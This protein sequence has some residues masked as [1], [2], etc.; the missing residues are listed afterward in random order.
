MEDKSIKEWAVAQHERVNQ[1]YGDGYPYKLHLNWVAAVARQFICPQTIFRNDAEVRVVINAC[2]LHDV[3][4][5][6][7]VS[8]NDVK[9]EC[10][11]MLANIAFAL[12]NEK[13][14]TRAERANDKYY[15]GIRA[16]KFADYVKL[17]D[18]IANMEYNL[19]FGGSML[20]KYR[21][22]REEFIIKLEV[23][24]KYPA[25]VEYLETL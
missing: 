21:A 13:G 10:G 6:T 5:D 3:I 18:R 22:E 16:V 9:D 15:K 25:M 14:K 7:G 12:T 11:A 1:T 2:Y 8:F 4:E 19:K 20:K 24:H 17:A 23:R